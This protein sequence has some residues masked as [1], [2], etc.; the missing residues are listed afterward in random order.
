MADLADR[1]GDRGDGQGTADGADALHTAF[2][3]AATRRAIGANRPQSV[4]A[5]E[6]FRVAE[7]VL[8][9]FV[10]P[11]TDVGLGRRVLLCSLDVGAVLWIADESSLPNGW[12]MLAVGHA[13]TTVDVVAARELRSVPPNALAWHVDLF[14]R[15]AGATLTPPVRDRTRGDATMV[16]AP[17]DAMATAKRE[18]RRV[19]AAII[20]QARADEAT[21]ARKI[22]ES[23]GRDARRLKSALIGLASLVDHRDALA[24]RHDQL[25]R[26]I[27]ACAR[28]GSYLRVPF[29]DRSSDFG[30]VDK[31]IEAMARAA[32]C[33]TRVV[34]LSDDWWRDPSEPLIA[35]RGAD[36]RPV[37]LLPGRRRRYRMFDPSDGSEIAIGP[38]NSGELAAEAYTFYRPAPEGVRSLGGIIR[39]GLAGSGSDPSML[40]LMGA[41]AGIVALATPLITGVVYSRVLPSN[42]DGRLLTVTS[43]LFGAAIA[44]AT[45]TLSR[46]LYTTRLGGRL[47]SNLQ[48]AVMDRALRLPSSFFREHDTGDISTRIDAA[49]LLQQQLSGGVVTSLLTLIFT[50]FSLVL[51][52]VYSPILAT[53]SI[54][55][56]AVTV[57][58]IVLLNVRM[59]N[60]QRDELDVTRRLSGE[61]FQI[62]NGVRKI[63]VAGAET[64]VMIKWAERF[65]EQQLATFAAGS[66][67]VWITALIAALPA[68]TT[69]VVFVLAGTALRERLDTG[70]FVAFTAALTQF[71]AA[72]TAMTF[73]LG[74]L[75]LSAVLIELVEPILTEPITD[76]RGQDPGRLTGQVS[77][78][79]AHFEYGPDMPPVLEGVSFDIAPGEFVA[80]TGPSGSGKST[81]LRLVLGLDLPSQGSVL[82]DGKDMSLLDVRQVRRQIGVVMQDARP[83]PGELLTTI[84][85]T[86]DRTEDEAWPAAEAA[87]LADD[88]RRMPMGMHTILGEGGSTFSGGQLQRLMIAKALVGRPR[89]L[90]FDE[91]T[92]ALDD[93]TQ[94]Q[95]TAVVEQMD[96]TRI[97]IAHRLSTIRAADRILVLEDGKLVQEGSFDELIA[98]DGPFH[99]LARRQ[100]L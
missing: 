81:L 95:V 8:D 40:L 96:A 87:G 13:D 11:T 23:A 18:L 77:V 53:I 46:N 79:D 49:Q 93:R 59:A 99:D 38:D 16:G 58:A 41:L 29:P 42:D 24:V 31:P 90:L 82:Y 62:F 43:I 48:P 85:G 64:R 52:F 50:S 33:R 67:K 57:G 75:L 21:E 10:Q 19:I 88:I 39:F 97:V 17:T 54:L 4:T 80:I 45:V 84:V 3:R 83:I 60:R 6:A 69:L 78:V 73:T 2:D 35:F 44:G 89:L 32:G 68:I 92:S 1:T 76:A 7:G 100:M 25:D 37:A 51:L 65:R 26:A 55:V 47:S 94:A 5:E 30:D 12:R 71:T 66:I 27:A 72:A 14:A 9:V 20:E 74:P 36:E 28:V 86:S 70:D 98:H 22:T 63:R 15:V 34:R 91:A 61:L 56:L